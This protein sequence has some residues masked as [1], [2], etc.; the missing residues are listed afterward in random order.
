MASEPKIQVQVTQQELEEIIELERLIAPMQKR[1]DELKSNVKALLI[2]KM[3]VEIGRFDATLI[4]FTGRHVPWRRGF[5]E[6]LGEDE[7]EKFKKRF[8]VHVRFE[9]KVEEHAVPPLWKD[10]SDSIQVN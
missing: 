4:R 2:H 6:Y 1:V 8:D 10:G 7:A 3:P 9:L 5:E